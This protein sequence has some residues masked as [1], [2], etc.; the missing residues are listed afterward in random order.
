MLS[1]C[2]LSLRFVRGRCT[3]EV[4]SA[5]KIINVLAMGLSLFV[6]TVIRIL[7]YRISSRRVC[8]SVMR[9]LTIVLSEIRVRCLRIRIIFRFELSEIF[10]TRIPFTDLA[11]T[12]FFFEDSHLHN[13]PSLF[14]VENVVKQ[15]DQ[16]HYVGGA[17]GIRE[18]GKSIPTSDLYS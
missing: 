1:V 14:G 3:R 8:A 6:P 7:V 9:A 15:C 2:V 5:A 10:G 4:A 17:F 13:T 16:R 18:G 11:V 12:G